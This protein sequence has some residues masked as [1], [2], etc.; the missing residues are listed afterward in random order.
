MNHNY[1]IT[2]FR[3]IK[4]EDT[5]IHER[6]VSID[7]SNV[8]ELPS[9]IV[10]RLEA[11]I[12]KMI[13]DHEETHSMMI[14]LENMELGIYMDVDTMKKELSLNAYVGYSYKEECITGKEIL[15]SADAD[16]SVAK[17]FF[18]SELNN[19]I[20]EQVKKIQSCVA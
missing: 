16:Y 3:I 20:F 14:P 1:K 4:E 13:A 7:L 15:N 2:D 9:I 17:K 6:I 18:F 19:Y 10:Q 5:D 8:L 12:N 11:I